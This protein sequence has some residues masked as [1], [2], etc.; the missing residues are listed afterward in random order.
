MGMSIFTSSSGMASLRAMNESSKKLSTAMNRLGTGLRINSAAD[1]AAGL[2]IGTR[3]QGQLSGIEVA[4]NNIGKASAMLQ[5]GEGAFE[6]LTNVLYRIKDLATQAADDSNNSDDRSA[7]QQEYDQLIGE[8]ANI[9]S[10]TAYGSEP[11]FQSIIPPMLKGKF[12]AD[13]QFQIGASQRETLIFNASDELDKVVVALQD[14]M[15]IPGS[16]GNLEDAEMANETINLVNDALNQVGGFRSHLGAT[17]NR[18]GH[19]AANL[20]NMQ[21]NVALNIGA[22]R[23]AD[24]AKEA[25]E[26]SRHSMLQQSSQAML[27]QS[28]AM[29]G[30]VMALLA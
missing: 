22:I 6:E 21:N 27:K 19:T 17:I 14:L 28:N 12:A 30:S 11:L 2:Q 13:M 5:T 25:S 29:S 1:D 24:F 15:T 8:A 4:N 20:E 7:M 23:D 16:P 3:L 26:M 18:L 9:M 10:N